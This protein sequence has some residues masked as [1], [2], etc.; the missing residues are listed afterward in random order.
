MRLHSGPLL[1]WWHKFVSSNAHF[2][3]TNDHEL[4][5]V[6]WCFQSRNL[7][8]SIVKY[9]GSLRWRYSMHMSENVMKGSNNNKSIFIDSWILMSIHVFFH[10]IIKLV[11]YL[12]KWFCSETIL[13]NMLTLNDH[14]DHS[15]HI[16]KK[17]TNN[18]HQLLVQK[19]PRINYWNMYSLIITWIL[20]K[21][22]HMLTFFNL[23]LIF[24]QSK[25]IFHGTT[26][27]NTLIVQTQVIYSWRWNVIAATWL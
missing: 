4:L 10:H 24:C 22:S 15:V 12:L 23:V 13:S 17:K 16:M 26:L 27:Q 5:L 8:R 18:I 2:R 3:V 20:Q 25:L 9:A 1:I 21:S 14:S 7:F 6:V 11:K 19:N